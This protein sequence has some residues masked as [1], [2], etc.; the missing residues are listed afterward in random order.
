M[1]GST[2][3]TGIIHRFKPNAPVPA[4]FYHGLARQDSTYIRKRAA[5]VGMVDQIEEVKCVV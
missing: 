4:D 5:E 2:E 1:I 3:N